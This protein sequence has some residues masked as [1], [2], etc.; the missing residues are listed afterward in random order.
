MI[1]SESTSTPTALPKGTKKHQTTN[2]KPKTKKFWGKIK[3]SAE[4]QKNTRQPM[5]CQTNKCW[6]RIRLNLLSGENQ[7]SPDNQCFAKWMDVWK[8]TRTSII[9]SWK[10]KNTKKSNFAVQILNLYFMYH[11]D[12]LEI[13]FFQKFVQT[14]KFVLHLMIFMPKRRI[15]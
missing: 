5:L 9:F 2:F 1:R 13:N 7:K 8:K 15:K 3:E 4:T 14:R 12:N 10:L 11:I 6:V